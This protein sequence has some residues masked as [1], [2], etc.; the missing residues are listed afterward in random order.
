MKDILKTDQVVEF[1][2]KL[3]PKKINYN[4][5]DNLLREAQKIY[6]NKNNEKFHIK[7]IKEIEIIDNEIN[8]SLADGR[9]KFRLKAICDIVFVKQKDEVLT[10]CL[11]ITNKSAIILNNGPLYCIATGDCQENKF[12][13]V[14]IEGIPQY[15][16]GMDRIVAIDCLAMDEIKDEK[17][18]KKYLI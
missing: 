10:K 8:P 3:D 17:V 18:I 6:K 11:K 2:I 15:T 16:P 12:Y 7:D 9:V 14:K 5:I 1:D 4:I 13:K